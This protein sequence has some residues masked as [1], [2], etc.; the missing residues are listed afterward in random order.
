MVINT[1]GLPVSITN[2]LGDIVLVSKFGSKLLFLWA[3]WC[4]RHGYAI[5]EGGS[6][7]TE[8]NRRSQTPTNVAMSVELHWVARSVDVG[9][10][11]ICLNILTMA[12]FLR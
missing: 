10:T 1:H 12:C 7:G 11:T 2:G 6:E 5:G 8:S 3:W 4:C 9:W